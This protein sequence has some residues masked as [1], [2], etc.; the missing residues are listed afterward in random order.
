MYPLF[1]NKGADSFR[2]K[3]AQ[4]NTVILFLILKVLYKRGIFLKV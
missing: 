1:L 3:I 4:A 2:G